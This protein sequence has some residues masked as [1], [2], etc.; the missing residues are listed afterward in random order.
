MTSRDFDATPRA[1]SVVE[2]MAPPNAR[3]ELWD[4]DDRLLGA[5][6]ADEQGGYRLAL[7]ASGPLANLRVWVEAEGFSGG[8]WLHALGAGASVSLPAFDAGTSAQYALLDY[9]IRREAGLS[10]RSVP[11]AAVATLAEAIARDLPVSLVAAVDALHLDGGAEGRFEPRSYALRASA[12]EAVA[13]SYRAALAEAAEG[14]ALEIACDPARIAVMFAVDMSGAALD[15]NGAPQLIRQP[16]KTSRVFLGLAADPTS[17]VVDASVPRTLVANDPRFAMVDDGRLGDEVAGDGIYTV[18]VPLPR[19][20]RI[21]Y[22]YTNGAAGEGFTGT[23]E[24]PGNARILEVRDVLTGRPDGQPDCLVVRRDAFGDEA[25]NKNFVNLHSAASAIGFGTDLGGVAEEQVGE[26]WVGGLG[27]LDLRQVPPLSPAGV[28]E[29][30]ENGVCERCP[31]PLAQDPNDRVPPAL[32]AAER[33][34]RTRV[35]LRFSEPV[36]SDDGADLGRY[37]YLNAQG[38]S[39]AIRAARVSGAEVWLKTGDT[40]PTAPARVRVR[41]LRDLAVE[42]NEL[43]QAE[44]A[45]APDTTAPR[46]VS[47][48]AASAREVLG[49]P[50]EDPTR[51]RFVVLRF[52]EALDVASAEDPRHYQIPGLD[53]RAAALD[54]DGTTVRLHTERHR[55][56][57]S[58]ELTVVGLRDWA[59]HHLEQTTTFLGF[60]L[61]K[62]RFRVVPGFAYANLD[63]RVRGLPRGEDLFLTGDP[64]AMARDLSGRDISVR[65]SGFRRTDVTG[66]PQFAL[67]P[68]AERY[69][70]Q[71]VYERTVLLPR[72][73]YAWKAAHGVAG[74]YVDA[75]S[76]T[77][78]EK[79]YKTLVTQNDATGVRVDPVTMIA[80]NG[81]SY[82]GAVLSEDGRD[83]PGPDRLFKRE[84]PDELC[85]VRGDGACPMIVVGTWRDLSLLPGGRP[86]D[87]DDGLLARPPHRPEQVDR[88]P[89]EL[90]ALEARDSFSLLFSFHE[91]LDPSATLDLRVFSPDDGWFREMVWLADPSLPAHQRVARTAHTECEAALAPDARF[92]VAW[93]G[94]RDRSGDEGLRWQT[95][96]VRGPAEC[97]AFRPLQDLEAPSVTSVVAESFERLRVRFSEAVD[98]ASAESAAAYAIYDADDVP[99]PVTAAQL[100]DDLRT[101]R[102]TT[103][104]QSLRAA[105]VL[106]V[107]GLR[108][109]ADPANVAD[110]QKVAFAGFGERVPPVLERARAVTSDE[111]LL[112]F[113]EALDTESALDVERYQVE[114]AELVGVDFGADPGRARLAYARRGWPSLAHLVRL[115]VAGAV[116]GRPLRVTVDGVRDLSGNPGGGALDVSVPERTPTVD[117]ILSY[118][119][120]DTEPVAGRVP[121]RALTV[122]ALGDVREGVFVVGARAGTDER[123]V[124]GAMGPVNDTLGGFA[125][126]GAPLEGIETMLSDSGTRGDAV[127][128]DGIFSVRI[129][130]VPLGTR[131]LW[132]AFA[133]YTVGYRDANPSDTAAAR[134]DAL[135]GPSQFGD[136]EEFPGHENGAVL[137]DDGDGDGVVHIQCLFGDEVT[138][139]KFSGDAPYVWVADDVAWQP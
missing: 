105:Y 56:D 17:P 102:L 115:R 138:Y 110:A 30:L 95:R 82:Q 21:I 28:P 135:P 120:S 11:P 74:E 3:V 127:Q 24:W 22:K 23:E 15:G 131:L 43:G 139:K 38:E 34:S 72:G 58:Y 86:R 109:R 84:A 103:A 128:G 41:R 31:A 118:R 13:A 60:A 49:T 4:P 114:G 88:R 126:E 37:L 107:S 9:E 96:V 46:L 51:G 79:V 61:Y 123:P 122:S 69:Q 1:P 10:W 66:W 67:V 55:K 97:T 81:A 83:A 12:P 57:H 121:P 44:M 65:A 80:E 32:V 77:T 124:A 54:A 52:D 19:G 129:P 104:R 29:A 5:A 99:L 106:V 100:E 117:V 132:K 70:G 36:R 47:A 8:Q 136:G 40:H 18:V 111:I 64:L 93:K 16:A 91:A 98:P 130:A 20:A 137:L 48:R 39:V 2:G 90:L 59:G 68:G 101:V 63:G 94:A 108:D 76:A 113:S 73:N 134:A 35:R 50:D 89:P 133:P 33:V 26:R 75:R 53:V 6:T 45:V 85:E 87:Y 42:P 112:R 119:L 14:F 116:A 92:E 71:P 25:S 7:I 27:R 78:L 62:V 125:P